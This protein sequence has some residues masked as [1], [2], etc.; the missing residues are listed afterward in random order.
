MKEYRY[1]KDHVVFW[2][3]DPG[4]CMYY[5]RWGAVGVYAN[6][7]KHN[8]KQLAVLR[9]GDYFGEMGLLDRGERSAT[10]AVLEKGTILNEIGDAEFGEFLASNPARVHDIM[11]QLSHKLRNA[12][13]EY[14][15]VCQA[16]R[17]VVGT[18]GD[19]VDESA[20]YHFAENEQLVAIH[21]KVEQSQAQS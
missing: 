16:V 14:L 7:A 18:D 11:S 19:E 6:Y 5:I 12:T 2:E 4:D 10:V 13:K 8:H 3:G 21:D 17:D 9:T 20:T 1:N 15:E